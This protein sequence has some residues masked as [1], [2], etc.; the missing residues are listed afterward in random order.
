M[1]LFLG[2]ATPVTFYRYFRGVV[3]FGTLRYQDSSSLLASSASIKLLIREG[4][5]NTAG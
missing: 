5:Q 2:S 3:T 4:A 1:S